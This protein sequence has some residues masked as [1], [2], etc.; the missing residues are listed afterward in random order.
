M[1]GRHCGGKEGGRE[2]R[3]EGEG[4]KGGRGREGEGGREGGKVGGRGE[5][6][7]GRE[8]EGGGY[9]DRFMNVG[10]IQRKIFRKMLKINSC[11]LYSIIHSKVTE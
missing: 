11:T 10:N 2:G 8:G 5:R 3:R 7:G 1:T 9:R 4:G 6:E